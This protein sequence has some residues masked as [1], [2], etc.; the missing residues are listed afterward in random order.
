MLRVGLTGGLGS[1]KSTVGAMLAARGAHLLQADEI[2]RELM[3]PG[4]PVFD[5]IVR[6]FGPA[7]LQ[8]DGTL[9]RPR[10]AQLAFG[11]KRIEELSAIVHPAVLARQAELADEF[12]R[13]VPG[14]VLVV[15]SA[16]LFETRHAGAGGW[17]SRFDRIVLVTATE[18]QK[19]ERFVSRGTSG[20]SGAAEPAELR[21]TARQRLAEQ[22]PDEQK[23]VWADYVL[24]N[25]GSLHDLERRVAALW[26]ALVAEAAQLKP[27]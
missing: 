16:L 12:Q 26:N 23:Q 7:V 15:E 6:Q 5:A 13:Q 17:K 25:G 2:G 18:E 22:I 19:V 3:Q 10:L 8:P 14:A 27:A 1:G 20:S 9:D 21:R 24:R 11:D 4:H